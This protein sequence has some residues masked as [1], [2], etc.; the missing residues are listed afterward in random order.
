MKVRV[1]C[2][3]GYTAE[4]LPRA[5]VI[6]DRRIEVTEIVDRWRGEDHEYFKIDASD[7][8]RY[9]LRLDRERREWE[10]ILFLRGA[11]SPR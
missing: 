8:D 6:G 7:G 5:V 9:I 11:P 1:L 10:V 4:E 2:Y 3:E